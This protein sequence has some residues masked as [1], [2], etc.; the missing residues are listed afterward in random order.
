MNANDFE[1]RTI[2]NHLIKIYLEKH[3]DKKEAI[4]K[5]ETL[6]QK[7]SFILTKMDEL[8]TIAQEELQQYQNYLNKHVVKNEKIAMI[9]TI[10]GYFTA[11]KLIEKALNDKILSIYW[12][13]DLIYFKNAKE[14][15]NFESFVKDNKMNIKDWKIME[16]I[17]TSPEA[18]IENIANNKPIYKK[19][20]TP[21]EQKRIEIFPNIEDGILEFTKLKQKIFD[22]TEIYFANEIITKWI[23]SF[24][25]IP[26]EYEMEKFS[27]LGFACDCNHEEYIAFPT[28]WFKELPKDYKVK[29]LQHIFSIKNEGNK[30]ILRLLGFKIKLKRKIK[31]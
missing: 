20:I 12:I 5:Y 9:D 6:K 16:F 21:Q 28:P 18:P 1:N 13:A 4:D 26:T 10:T 25:V 14:H 29:P 17:M 23:N 31:F 19:E 15:Y 3:P 11:Q 7:K 30:K 22:N 24:C 27:T 2:T 8:K